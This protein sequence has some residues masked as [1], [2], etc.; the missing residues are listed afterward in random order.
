MAVN[1]TPNAREATVGPVAFGYA[2]IALISCSSHLRTASSVGCGVP[3][4]SIGQV[5]GSAAAARAGAVV[6]TVVTVRVATT[7]AVTASTAVAS[8]Y[9]ISSS[10]SGSVGAVRWAQRPA[11]VQR[12]SVL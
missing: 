8:L 3:H 2:W 9:F 11:R 6:V 1:S 10:L 12:T 5:P 4:W 7:K